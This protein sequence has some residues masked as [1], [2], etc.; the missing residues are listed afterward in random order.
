MMQNILQ[1]RILPLMG[2]GLVYNKMELKVKEH[3][4]SPTKF[5]AELNKI[6]FMGI[7]LGGLSG[8]FFMQSLYRG[9]QPIPNLKISITHFLLHVRNIL[10]VLLVSIAGVFKN[11]KLLNNPVVIAY[12]NRSERI[13]GIFDSLLPLMK[14]EN[15]LYINTMGE[16][17]SPLKKNEKFLD[18]YKTTIKQYLEWRKEYKSIKRELALTLSNLKQVYG[19][20]DI[21]LTALN[22]YLKFQT[23]HCVALTEKFNK[24][25]PKYILTD[26]DRGRYNNCVVVTGNKL[27]IPTYSFIH[28]STEPP[29]GFIPILANKLLC[30][31]E[32]QVKQFASLGIKPER[33]PIVGNGKIPSPPHSIKKHGHNS[34]NICFAGNNIAMNERLALFNLIGDATRKINHIDYIMKIHPAE[35]KIDYQSVQDINSHIKII[36]SKELSNKS[37]F[38]KTDLLLV[39]NSTIMIEAIAH[40]VPVLIINHPEVTFPIG[41]G[42]H[43]LVIPGY[44]Q[45]HT[46]RELEQFILSVQRDHHCLEGLFEKCLI[47]IHEYCRYFGDESIREQIKVFENHV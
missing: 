37:L 15:I 45:I 23:L 29:T 44:P 21:T 22:R 18:I 42:Q 36:E 17:V 3:N 28:G 32:I 11:R 1:G 40:G 39:H 26:F 6:C 47:F 14:N 30:W 24:I 25:K 27:A 12:T 9:T 4:W 16:K 33:L 20:N 2:A 10:Y 34:L 46:S 7:P 41:I 38:E 35:E 13:F 43:L 5:E 8:S 31:G 19:F